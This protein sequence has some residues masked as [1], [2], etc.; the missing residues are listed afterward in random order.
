MLVVLCFNLVTFTKFDLLCKDDLA[1]TW[2]LP[3][4]PETMSSSLIFLH[5]PHHP[6]I[7]KLGSEYLLNIIWMEIMIQQNPA[8]QCWDRPGIKLR[9]S[10]P[11]LC[12]FVDV[13]LGPR[14]VFRRLA[15][16]FRHSYL[17]QQHLWWGRHRRLL[18]LSSSRSSKPTTVNSWNC[19][20]CRGRLRFDFLVPAHEIILNILNPLV[21]HHFS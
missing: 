7:S 5:Y 4:R 15:E 14:S 9:L 6:W 10:T 20:D 2:S 11:Q 16:R 12:F 18:K 8:G 19:R 3:S 17:S 1:P 21:H 13:C